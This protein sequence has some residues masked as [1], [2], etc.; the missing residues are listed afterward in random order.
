VA[1]A[2]F[3]R[4]PPGDQLVRLSIIG[5]GTETVSPP[6]TYKAPFQQRWQ[7]KTLQTQLVNVSET[8][9]KVDGKEI[10]LKLP[11]SGTGTTGLLIADPC[12]T[13][14]GGMACPNGESM[15]I[16]DHLTKIIN[17]LVGSDEFDFW[18]ILGDNFYDQ[19]GEVTSEF[20]KLVDASA[21]AKPFITVPGNHDF[22]IVGGPRG[23]VH[24]D[25]GYAFMQFYGQDTVA[26]STEVPFNFAGTADALELA[27][28]DNFIFVTQI[29]DV[30][31]FGYSGAHGWSQAQPHADEFC[32]L[33]GSTPTINTGVIV[34]HWNEKNLG[35]QVGMDTPDLYEKLRMIDGCNSKRLLYFDGH[36]HCNR[37]TK[38]SSSNQD[39]LNAVG[40]MVGG[41]GM[42]G[43]CNPE[44]GFTVFQSVP[45]AYGGQ[46]VRV[47]YF[48]VAVQEG[49]GPVQ[50]KFDELMSCFSAHGY[51]GCR[52]R[53]ATPFRSVPVAPKPPPS[54]S[55]APISGN[56]ITIVV[57]CIV[58]LC[59]FLI[60]GALGWR[61]WRLRYRLG[62]PLVATGPG[63]TALGGS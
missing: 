30:A 32:K 24:D 22:W 48:Q 39:P 52:D 9:I 6:L 19:H 7:S 2:H 4:D 63:E 62:Q 61:K 25:L 5:D 31:F 13:G 15:K 10:K 41:A 28:G 50:D 29:G 35:C 12:F 43:T 23:S 47:D 36:M 11:R 14:R 60:V 18:G 37:V 59:C 8:T 51:K 33:L 49:G 44:F 34:G 26:A 42:L 54:P 3:T 46:N 17:Q 27:D 38:Y 55:P 40:F 1:K 56:G 53:Y 21:K 45:D 57:V 16:L 20:F 58:A